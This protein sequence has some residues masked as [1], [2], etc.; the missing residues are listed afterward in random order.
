MAPQGATGREG[1]C[2]LIAALLLLA[3]LASPGRLGAAA[4]AADEGSGGG[5]E[6]HGVSLRSLLPSA[7]CTATTTTAGIG[8]LTASARAIRLPRSKTYLI[9]YRLPI[10]SDAHIM[11]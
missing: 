6:W 7:V 10:T 5:V 2:F 8:F 11:Q 9:S 3:A 1:R 4:A